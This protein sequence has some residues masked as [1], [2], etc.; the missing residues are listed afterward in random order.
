MP[1]Q[2]SVESSSVVG[3]HSGGAGPLQEFLDTPGV[4]DVLVN[5]PGYAWIDTGTGLEQRPVALPTAGSVREL[6]VFLAASGGRRLDDASPMVDAR[7]PG[8]VRLHAVLPPVADGCTVISLRV[9]R[10]G[11]HSL[12]DMETMGT[13]APAIGVALRSLVKARA[14]VVISGAT[15]SGKTTLVSAL[16]SCVSPQ[17]RMVIIEEAGE[18]E[19]RHPHVVR[20]VERRPNIEGAGAVSLATLVRESLRMRPDRIVLGECRG[21]EIADVLTAANTGHRGGMVTLHANSIHEVPARVVALCALAGMSERAAVLQT[22]AG[23]QA[24]A[25]MERTAH[26]RVVS[27]VGIFS[28]DADRLRVDSALRVTRDGVEEGPA[29]HRWRESVEQA[30]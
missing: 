10:G 5:A 14:S 7:L 25:H 12:E 20:L 1:L 15:G 13:V 6:A 21:V 2:S 24:V 9:V 22:S 11:S 17:A 28:V 16:L 8:G 30:S 29:W 26:G 27:E 19:P 3:H 23:F 4:T 18:L